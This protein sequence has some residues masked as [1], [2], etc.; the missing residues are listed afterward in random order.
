MHTYKKSTFR[1]RNTDIN[2]C[3]P[4]ILDIS[5]WCLKLNDCIYYIYIYIFSNLIKYCPYI[6]KKN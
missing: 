2:L 6:I 4:V 1:W 5:F 3:L